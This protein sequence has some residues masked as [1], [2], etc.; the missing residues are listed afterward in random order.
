MS[1]SA[2]A[3]PIA[4]SPATAVWLLLVLATGLIWWLGI[5]EPAVCNLAVSALIVIAFIKIR[6]VILYFMNIRA[7]P[8][9]LRLLLEAWVFGIG[10]AVLGLY[11]HG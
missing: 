7:A 5:D 4:R 9:P 6:L 8:W 11:G 3:P 10:D 1:A 2:T